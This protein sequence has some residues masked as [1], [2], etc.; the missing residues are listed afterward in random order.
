[1]IDE[2]NPITAALVH[3]TGGTGRHAPGIFTMKAGHENVGRTGKPA[4]HFWPHLN[5]LAQSRTDG[6]PLIGFT[7]HFTGMASDAFFGVLE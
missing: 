6:Q 4:D 2:N 7:L 1:V 5:N 3:G